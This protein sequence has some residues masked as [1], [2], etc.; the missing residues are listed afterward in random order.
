[1]EDN[2]INA[3]RADYPIGD[4]IITYGWGTSWN[5]GATEVVHHMGGGVSFTLNHDG[6][7]LFGTV[8]LAV[9][10]GARLTSSGRFSRILRNGLSIA[11]ICKGSSPS[12]A[13]RRLQKTGSLID[14]LIHD[15]YGHHLQ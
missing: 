8:N 9:S 10:G 11:E 4:G 1:M 5:W 7:P 3:I 6:I 2:G 12:G 14:T 15:D 13:K